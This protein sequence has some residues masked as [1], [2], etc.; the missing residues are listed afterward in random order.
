MDLTKIFYDPS[1]D[2][3]LGVFG[4]KIHVKTQTQNEKPVVLILSIDLFHKTWSNWIEGKRKYCESYKEYCGVM[5]TTSIE[6]GEVI[7]SQIFLNEFDE[8]GVVSVVK[9]I[10]IQVTSFYELHDFE[11]G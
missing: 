9:P 11:H 2:Q 8:E 4:D 3:I 10:V 7:E 5:G 1:S 6:Q